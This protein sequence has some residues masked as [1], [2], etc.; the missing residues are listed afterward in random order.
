MRRKLEQAYIRQKTKLIRL[1]SKLQK[2]T[3]FV[4]KEIEK[5]KLLLLWNTN[6]NQLKIKDYKEAERTNNCRSI[7][8][9]KWIPIKR[10]E[11]LNG[12]FHDYNTSLFG[13][14]YT[15]RLQSLRLLYGSLILETARAAY[16]LH[17]LGNQDGSDTLQALGYSLTN[18]ENEMLREFT[19]IEIA[20]QEVTRGVSK[21]KITFEKEIAEIEERLSRQIEVKDWSCSRWIE[22]LKSAK[23]K[24]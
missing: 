7:R 13:S 18:T 20:K 15:S 11:I 12:I 14:S 8:K 19:D 4:F 3:I 9:I 17:K 24:S 10:K 2:V 1:F 6:L 5:R 21:K 22:V 23:N 16:E